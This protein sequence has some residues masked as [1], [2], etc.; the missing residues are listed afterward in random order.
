LS[1]SMSRLALQ[2]PALHTPN[3]TNWFHSGPRDLQPAVWFDD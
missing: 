3:A 2:F 1:A